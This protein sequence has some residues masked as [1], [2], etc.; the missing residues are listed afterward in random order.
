MSSNI[1]ILFVAVFSQNSTNNSQSRGFTN[2]GCGVYEY[3]FRE[4]LNILK[5]HNLRDKDLINCVKELKPQVVVFSKG[6]G[7]SP[8]VIEECNKY[9]STI[10][11]YMDALHNFDNNLIEK[12]KL[13]DS[14][15]CGVPGV[16]L[17]AKKY[18]SKVHF[19]DQCYDEKLNFPME[20]IE[21]DLDI[22]FIGNVGSKI[23]GNRLPYINYIKSKHPTFTHFNGIYGLE[24][25]KILNR[26]KINLNFTPI[27]ATGSSV[28]L[29]KILA[30]KG[31]L[32]T[33]PWDGME[34]RFTPGE[35]FIVF[36]SP[37]DFS[38]KA[39]YY[40]EHPEE[41][42]KIREQGYQTIQNSHPNEWAKNI[43]NTI[44]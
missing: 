20:H 27:D 6:D 9:S 12:I 30:T 19:V 8:K 40:L 26:S 34:D 32:M 35:D 5:S 44:L 16:N 14:F 1:N 23:H 13:V 22:T 21:K 42:D 7:I 2:I 10:L 28:R 11:W 4:R 41:R 15:S 3:D 18:T 43:I 36:T 24:H 39:K 25:T 38:K 33:L 17:E 31:F 29:H 37:E